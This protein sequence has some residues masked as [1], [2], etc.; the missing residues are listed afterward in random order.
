MTEEKE[1]TIEEKYKAAVELAKKMAA[2][3]QF[4]KDMAILHRLYA[5]AVAGEMKDEEGQNVIPEID[6]D[7]PRAQYAWDKSEA[8]LMEVYTGKADQPATP[9]II[10]PDGM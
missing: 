10:L 5:S 7:D 6:M 8:E 1:A 9:R 4:W 2:E 3:M